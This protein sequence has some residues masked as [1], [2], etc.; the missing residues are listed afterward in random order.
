MRDFKPILSLAL[1]CW[2]SLPTFA[3][4]LQLS[5]TDTV[6][7]TGDTV[8]ITLRAQQ[9]DEIVSVQFSLQWDVAV[10]EYLAYQQADLENIAIGDFQSENGE[11]R[12]SWFDVAGEG[13][14]LPDGSILV[15]LRFK[16]VGQPG[17][18][19][20][21]TIT[22]TPLAIQIFRATIIPG[23]YDPVLLDQQAGSVL[24]GTPGAITFG[25]NQIGC[26]GDGDGAVNLL[27][28]GESANY[29]FAWTG[30]D[31][32]SAD[33]ADISGLAPGSYDLQVF[34]LTG[35]LFL[36]TTIQIS[37]PQVLAMSLSASTE[38]DCDT[39]TGSAT[40]AVAGGTAPYTFQLVGESQNQ[41]GFFNQL[42]AGAYTIIVAD[43]NACRDTLEFEVTAPDAPQLSLP[44]TLS[45]CGSEPLSIDAGLHDAYAWSTGATSESIAVT[46]TGI[47]SVTVSNS[48][49]CSAS[50]T[51]QVLTGQAPVAQIPLDF[52][53]TC[54]GDTFQLQVSGG[55]TYQWIDTSGTLSALDI[56][57]PLVATPKY[58]GR[59]FVIVSNACGADT[60]SIRA[61]PYP[62]NATAGI[63]TCL[64]YQTEGRLAASGGVL[65]A[66][67]DAPYPVSDKTIPDPVV[68]PL[69]STIYVVEIM[70]QNG[71]FTIDSVL[72]M[73][74]E[75]PAASI[76]A[77]NMITPNGDGKNDILEFQGAGKFGQNT[78]K[79]YNRWGDLVYQKLNY[80]L[81]DERFDGTRNGSPLPA[82]NYY[83]ILSFRSGEIKQTLTIVRD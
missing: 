7:F 21:I 77:I 71:C 13:N 35:A 32:F 61:L 28:Q 51:V 1:A 48:Q 22:G 3:Q 80:Q 12:F 44:D 14:T 73:I 33:E 57:N 30:P 62:V 50:D 10:I 76:R 4:S 42:D 26:N 9:F 16:V 29:T 47:Y 75:D 8:A 72:V 18:E 45:I 82:A 6:S 43:V 31:G 40:L 2:L 83:Y 46:Q 69:E 65:Y 39:P 34:D 20:P 25:V 59:Y 70:D 68:A 53:Q 52:F 17:D 58:N 64:I 67:E 56:P 15:I 55:D 37:E 81:D 54:P 38:S 41:D 11:L 5:L 74:S 49:G 27:L 23:L 24:V 19:T 66:W 63:D 60:V 78:L 79:I 36:D